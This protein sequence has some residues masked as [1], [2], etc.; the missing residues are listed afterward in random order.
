[1]K[2]VNYQFLAVNGCNVTQVRKS[3]GEA[4]QVGKCAAAILL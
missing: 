2:G 3:R 1:M 4:L